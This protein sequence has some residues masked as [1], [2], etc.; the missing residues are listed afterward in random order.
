[1]R[2]DGDNI[3]FGQSDVEICLGRECSSLAVSGWEMPN[4][5]D[6]HQY[7]ANRIGTMLSS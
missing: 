6:G 1:M 5:P 7:K 4:E 3:R 2:P